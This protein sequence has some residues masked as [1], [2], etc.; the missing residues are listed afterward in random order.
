MT[1]NCALVA[2][3]AQELRAECGKADPVRLEPAP[4]KRHHEP[5][6]G[7]DC[8]E[9]QRLY[10]AL[11]R[12]QP[13]TNPR[14]YKLLESGNRRIAQ[15]VIEEAGEVALEAVKRHTRGVVRESADL[16]YHLL[17]LWHRADIEP[18][19]VWAEMRAFGLAEKCQKSPKHNAARGQR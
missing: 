15:K 16:L 11:S 14:T 19:E 18:G 4:H 9:L 10:A 17:V 3:R 8:S 6:P 7:G 1:K 13:A 12:V 5:V 2:W